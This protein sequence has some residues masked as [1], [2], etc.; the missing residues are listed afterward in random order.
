[1]NDAKKF[2]I[3]MGIVSLFAD[4]TYEGAKGIAGQYLALLG[5]S[6]IIVGFTAGFG[7]LAGYA[8]RFLSGYLSDKTLKHWSITFV[9]YF[10]N[11][12][13]VPLLA[14][15]NRWELAT[16]L[17]I[18][19]RI[20]KG[21]RTPPRDAMLSYATAH[22]GRGWGFGIHEALDQIGAVLGPLIM[23]TVLY[24]KGSY[25]TCFIIL[26]LP[27]ILCISILIIS[28]FLYPKPEKLEIETKIG[29]KSM[30]KAYWIYV[31]AASLIA[32]GFADFPLIAYHIKQNF[33]FSDEIIP[34]L[35]SLAMAIDGIS[36][37]IFGRMFDKF[38]IVILA[39]SILLSSFFAPLTFLGGGILVIIGIC[40][41]GMG[42][43][44]NESIM[45]SMVTILSPKEK[46]GSAFGTFHM[47][48]GISWFIGSFIMGFL[49]E[50]SLVILALFSVVTQLSSLIFIYILYK[51]S[52]S[53]ELP[54]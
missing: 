36:A 1:M 48:F 54:S 3:L 39:V 49:Y 8:V 33:I 26:A 9:G 11:L 46:R 53:T 23:F 22:T 43:G 21:I 2:I 4:M 30:S 52:Y 42:M 29:I 10:I 40:L 20:G 51:M 19:E 28:Y 12:F 44:V 5:A 47:I 32:L 35:F 50:I 45:R 27:A 24:L 25:K 16:M 14:F 38:G 17:L 13:A 34:L 41:W 31:A 6:A 7:E 18:A 37:L 15:V